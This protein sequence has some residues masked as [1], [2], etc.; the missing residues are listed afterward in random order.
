[1]EQLII[2]CLDH[3]KDILTGVP[4]DF[5]TV[6]D[7]DKQKVMYIALHCV[8]NGPV[9]VNKVTKFPLVGDGQIKKLCNCSNSQWKLFCK[10]V[11]EFVFKTNPNIE[12][13]T[14]KLKKRYWPLYDL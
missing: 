8:L 2:T 7:E 5:E 1:M 14:M 13:T 3:L 4:L 6:K 10:S 11:A 9:G 12:C